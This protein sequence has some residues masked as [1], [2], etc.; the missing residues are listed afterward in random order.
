M[1]C[2][3]FEDSPQGSH[4]APWPHYK[5]VPR[6]RRTDVPRHCDVNGAENLVYQFEVASGADIAANDRQRPRWRIGQGLEYRASDLD[7]RLGARYHDAQLS[8][9]S[10]GKAT[11]DWRIDE[12]VMSE[13]H[14]KIVHS[15]RCLYAIRRDVGGASPESWVAP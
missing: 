15:H 13:T 11:G 5:S 3:A 8:L 14:H 12:L 7:G 2:T 6:Q 10:S 4:R 1:R 9:R